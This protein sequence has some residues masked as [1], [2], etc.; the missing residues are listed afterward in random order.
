MRQDVLSAAKNNAEGKI[1]VMKWTSV[2]AAL[3]VS[4]LVPIASFYAQT[5]AEMNATAREDFARAD[6]D[7]NKT[8]Q[9]VLAKL[10]DSESKQKLKEKQRAW[11]ASRDAEAA[12]VAK[13]ASG[14]SI[15]PML[16]YETMTHLTRERIKELNAMLDRGTGS[17]PK[18]AASEA[19][20]KQGNSVS[21]TE[22]TPRPTPES[23]CPDKKWEYVGG[24]K[25]KLVKAGTN[26]NA[27][28][29]HCFV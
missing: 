20:S 21:Q 28:P 19:E 26:L 9:A 23:I 29:Q 16:R 25:P 5:Q 2:L 17:G 8:Y 22:P 10:R 13:E 3:L 6:A 24:E 14:G 27:T 11:I 4:L 18:L 7:L 1:D 15:A 12:R